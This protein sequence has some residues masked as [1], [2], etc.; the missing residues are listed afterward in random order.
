MAGMRC[1]AL[2]YVA[3]AALLAAGCASTP[4]PAVVAPAL[5]ET[6]PVGVVGDAADDPAIWVANPPGDSLVV[7]TQKQGGLIVYDLAGRQVQ[8][9]PGGRPNN[10]DLR[11]DFP[12]PAGAAPIIGAGDRSD[13]TLVIWR[14]DP[15]A[16]RLDAQS[17]RIPTGFKEV[18]GF[19]LGRL[20]ADFVAVATDKDSGDIGMWRLKPGADGSPG[21]ERIASFSLGSITE[22]C[23]VD[24][25]HGVVFLAQELVG[26]WEVPLTA[27]DGAGRKLIDQ[28]KPG[29]RLVSDVEGLSLWTQADGGYLVA[30]VQGDSRYAVYDRKAPHAYRGSFRIGPSKDGKADGVSGTDGIDISSAPLGPDLPQGLMV[31]Q[32][33]ENTDPVAT[34]DFKYVSWAEIAAALGL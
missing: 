4:V 29:G 21:A 34:Q 9:A 26:I 12:W 20:G 3:A 25:A 5:L 27:A 33:D 15:K 22:G 16:R 18:Y 1:S 14:L 6:P 24:D 28:V 32:D 7:A 30:S 2:G 11:P 8:E 19:C 23:V 13:N 31:T 10:V 17:A